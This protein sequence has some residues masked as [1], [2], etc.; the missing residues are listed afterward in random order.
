[1]SDDFKY[2]AAHQAS[3][4]FNARRAA[5]HADFAA[6]ESN[7]DEVSASQTLQDLARLDMEEQAAARLYQRHQD[8]QRPR[9]DYASPE[10]RAARRPEEMDAHDLATMWSGGRFK[11][12]AQDVQREFSKLPRYKALRGIEQK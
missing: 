8:A 1:M 4:E 7:G 5:L 9:A 2:R 3:R 11:F 12:T 10:Q 6:H